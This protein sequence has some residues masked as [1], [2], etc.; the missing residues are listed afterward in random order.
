ML[1]ALIITL[2]VKHV[3]ILH[4]VLVKKRQLTIPTLCFSRT[5]FIAQCL[6]NR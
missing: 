6:K 1:E 2:L 5:V 3:L 4:A